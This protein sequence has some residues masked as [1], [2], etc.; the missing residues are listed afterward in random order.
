MIKYV[1]AAGAVA[2]LT[3]ATTVY[4]DGQGAFVSAGAGQSSQRH[5]GTA[6][7]VDGGYRWGVARN[8]YIGLEGGFHDLGTDKVRYADTTAFADITGA[9]QITATGKA[10]I[11]TKAATFGINARWDFADKVYVIAHG[12]IAR[13]RYRMSNEGTSTIDNESP[14]ATHIAYSLYDTRWYAGAGFGFDFT[15]QLSLQFT[16][17]HYP[18]HYSI[19]GFHIRNN[20]D[21][22][23]TAVE[24]RF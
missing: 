24:Y 3:A 10:H 1:I 20:L 13:Y 15:P 18:Q 9:H 14:I 6:W 12:G 22:Y 23:S 11:G 17:D 19:Y 4:A 5:T 16:Y 21:T 2:A 7:G 8:L